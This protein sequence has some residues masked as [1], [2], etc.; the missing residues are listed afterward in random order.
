[1]KTVDAKGKMC[2]VPLIMTKKALMEAGENEDLRVW[3]DNET[4]MK[5]VKRFL[6][7]HQMTVLVNRVGDVWELMVNK[8]GEMKASVRAE[9]Y[10]STDPG[11]FGAYVIAVQKDFLGDGDIELG[12]ILLKAFINT[13]PD[14]DHKPATVIFLN[15]GIFMV[16]EGSPVL[17]AIKKLEQIE[18]E[19][20]VCG[21]CLDF[22]EKKEQLAV[23]KVS[24]MYDILDRL[25]KASKVVYT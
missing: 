19:I 24:N 1:M 6:E 20:L 10:C 3:V 4:S 9:S 2:P 18:I 16:M 17:D 14:T 11:S 21:T 8:T 7:D 25:T 12:K 13:L 22:Y 5:N 23:G 15:S